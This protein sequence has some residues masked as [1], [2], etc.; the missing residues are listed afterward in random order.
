[1]Q[2]HGVTDCHVGHGGADLVHPAGVLVPQDVRQRGSHGGIPLA[3][4]DVQVGAAHPGAPDSYDD[5]ERPANR[6]L[7]YLVDRWLGVERV[8]TDGLHC[9]SSPSP[10]VL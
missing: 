7:W 2:D 4:D 1:M 9:A 5:V 10:D 6:R 8:Q 3:L